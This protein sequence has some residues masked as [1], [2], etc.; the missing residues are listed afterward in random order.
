MKH[1]CKYHPGETATWY[2]PTDGIHFCED[3]VAS[4]DSVDGGRARCFVCNKPLKQVGRQ[5]AQD[6]FWR[7]LSHFIQYPMSRDTMAVAV[8]LVLGCVILPVSWIGIGVAV[9]LGLPLGAL[10]VAAV[11]ETVSGRMRPPTYEVL[12]QSDYYAKGVQFWILFAAAMVG[13]GFCFLHFGMIEGAGIALLAWLFLTLALVQVIVDGSL[14]AVLGIPR[15]INTLAVLAVDYLLASLFLFATFIGAAIVVSVFYDLLPN[16]LG[17]PVSALILAWFFLM[18]SHLLGYLIC[19]H[20]ER[21]GYTPPSQDDSTVKHRRA[22]RPEEE[23]RQAVLMR[24]GKFDKV[25][26]SYKLK[27]EKHAGSLSFNEQY[28]KLLMALGRKEDLLENATPYLSLLLKNEQEYRVIDLVKRYREMEPGFKPGTAQ[29]TW[30][31]AKLLVENGEKKMALNMLLDLHKRAPTWPGLV[32]A[33]LFVATLLKQDFNL[34]GKAEQYIR[35]VETR[36]RDP[37]SQKLAQECRQ[38]LALLRS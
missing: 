20:S 15:L 23:R 30:D 1:T 5:I 10:A 34:S 31:V 9:L 14:L 33:Y 25:V 35:F 8:L 36:F 17:L 19:Q 28:E 16:F 37:K 11:E 38:E 29:G 24:E 18:T 22:R 26:S 13:M 3:C 4:D 21:L 27:L 7:I 2:C 32:E 6:P 12:K